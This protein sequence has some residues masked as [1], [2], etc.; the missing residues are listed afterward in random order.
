MENTVTTQIKE[1]PLNKKRLLKRYLMTAVSAVIFGLV[2][3]T[4]FIAIEPT[5]SGLL[6]PDEEK[7][8][9]VEFPEETAETEILPE[10]MLTLPEVPP[11]NVTVEEVQEIVSQEIDSKT[12][13]APPLG[14]DD[15]RNLSLALAKVGREAASSM[16]TVSMVTEDTDWFD[17]S[18]E[19]TGSIPGVL[20]ADNGIEKLI[21][22]KAAGLEEAED[23][24]VTFAD[25]VR[26]RAR[27]EACDFRTNLTV[28]AVPRPRIPQ[29]TLDYCPEMP[30]GSSIPM[31]IE[32]MPVIALYPQG[33]VAYG[34]VS[35]ATHTASYCDI[36][37][38][39]LTT[40]IY[41]PASPS[42]ILVNLRGQ[43][44]GIIDGDHSQSDMANGISA[45][46]IS[47][48]RA[49][50]ENLSNGMI[51]PYAGIIGVDIP[52][53]ISA[54][55]GIPMGAYIKDTDLNS[56]AMRSG[57]RAGDIVVS[58]DGK[59]VKSFRSLTELL[60]ACKSASEHTFTILRDSQGEYR[61]EEYTVV[62]D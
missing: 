41:G 38:R 53:E 61:Q 62:L 24:R 3:C 14:I 47:D 20:I 39:L 25:G 32:G 45:L 28:L 26:A 9:I 8:S 23:L 7:P 50:I 52:E 5:V 16:V 43:L 11:E 22:T 57:L 18:Y 56:P 37:V 12:T 31:Q 21:L 59:E 27:V 54:S 34:F 15:I 46:G 4:T 33:A 49:L 6:R 60:L 51:L 29:K 42:G 58:F 13:E 10:D 30:L 48:L 36:N 2:A 44:V 40:D 19:D 17:N 55:Q 35:L 1:R